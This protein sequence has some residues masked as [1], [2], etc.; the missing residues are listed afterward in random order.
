MH[1]GEELGYRSRCLFYPGCVLH[2]DTASSYAQVH[3]LSKHAK[4]TKHGIWVTQVRHSR[5]QNDKGE[6]LPVQYVVRKRVQLLCGTW[7]WRKGGTQKKDGFWA[8]IRKHVSRRAVSSNHMDNLRHRAYF[9]QWVYWKSADPIADAALGRRVTADPVDM[10]A[11]LG[12]LRK[13]LVDIVGLSNL[14]EHSQD[15]WMILVK[16][17]NRSWLGQSFG[18]PLQPRRCGISQVSNGNGTCNVLGYCC[19]G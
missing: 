13:R 16:S 17:T 4:Y 10:L 9:Y 19:D 18:Y 5:K 1:R 14:E 15:W 7:V 6:W 12:A 2:C 3:R 8:S 11:A